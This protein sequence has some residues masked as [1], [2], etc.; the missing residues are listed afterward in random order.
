MN[1]YP[2]SD[3]PIVSLI[4]WSESGSWA[5]KISFTIMEVQSLKVVGNKNGGGG[6]AGYCSKM[7]SNHGDRCLFNF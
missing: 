7:V 2:I 5:E 1:R 4:R 6:E 3:S